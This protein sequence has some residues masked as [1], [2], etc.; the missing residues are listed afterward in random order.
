MIVNEWDFNRIQAD[1]IMATL[2]SNFDPA[3]A[4]ELANYLAAV[5][6]AIRTYTGRLM[7]MQRAHEEKTAQMRMEERERAGYE[8]LELYHNVLREGP[9]NNYYTFF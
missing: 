6:C 1:R 4:R 9:P 5:E 2:D 8:A 7:N 3:V